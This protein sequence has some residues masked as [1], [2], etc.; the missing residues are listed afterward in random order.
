MTQKPGHKE[1]MIAHDEAHLFIKELRMRGCQDIKQ[2]RSRKG[3][4]IVMWT[5]TKESLKVEDTWTK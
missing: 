3:R 2:R 1:R 4:S 5:E